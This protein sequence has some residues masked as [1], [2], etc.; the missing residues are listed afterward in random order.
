M[1]GLLNPPR[2]FCTLSCFSYFIFVSARL[3]PR[4]HSSQSV[5]A[6]HHGAFPLNC[7]LLLLL[8]FSPLY[9]PRNVISSIISDIQDPPP[10]GN[11]E[12][13]AKR[14]DGRHAGENAGSTWRRPITVT[15]DSTVGQG[16]TTPQDLRH[17]RRRGNHHRG[18]GL[19]WCPT[20]FLERLGRH[21]AAVRV[22]ICKL[23]N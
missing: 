9:R 15:P 11:C 1:G 13:P 2:T 17:S 18:A 22:A 4:L 19:Y 21:V 7:F 14:P 16:E 23:R 6:V 5:C 8:V 3:L 12:T 10:H 20:G